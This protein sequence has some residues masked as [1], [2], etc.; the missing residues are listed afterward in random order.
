[1]PPVWSIGG[2]IV[3]SAANTSGGTVQSREAG[4]VSIFSLRSLVF[5]TIAFD[6]DVPAGVRAL[7]KQPDDIVPGGMLQIW[8]SRLEQVIWPPPHEMTKDEVGLI[9][10]SQPDWER[11]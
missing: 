5:R 10:H 4:N 3:F 7:I 6:R 8:P 11:G 2:P 1:M 9:A